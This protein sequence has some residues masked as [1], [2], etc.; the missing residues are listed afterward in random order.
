MVIAYKQ[1]R[2]KL[3]I[4]TR[5]FI[6]KYFTNHQAIKFVLIFMAWHKYIKFRL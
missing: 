5:Y 4:L 2:S 6:K 1:E 3:E